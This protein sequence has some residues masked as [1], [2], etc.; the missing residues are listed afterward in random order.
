MKLKRK[1][2]LM[3]FYIAV[4]S[5]GDKRKRR[6]EQMG[7]GGVKYRQQKDTNRSP[8]I[9]SAM[10]VQASCENSPPLSLSVGRIH[11]GAVPVFACDALWFYCAP[12]N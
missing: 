7:G 8:G 2:W 6:E 3:S 4:Y 11:K 1:T 5:V 12:A 9:L 10:R